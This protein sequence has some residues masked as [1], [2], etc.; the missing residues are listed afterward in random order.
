M[1]TT[2]L[3]ISLALAA[4]TPSGQLDSQQVA[5]VLR[6]ARAAHD[7]IHYIHAGK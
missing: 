7:T 3:L 4:C 6:L 1:K 2:I 5:D